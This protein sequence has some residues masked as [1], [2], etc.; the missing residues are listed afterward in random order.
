MIQQDTKSLTGDAAEWN[1]LSSG[2]LNYS[3]AHRWQL[4][5][6]HYFGAWLGS[7]TT[8]D[9]LSI[10][11]VERRW[12]RDPIVSPLLMSCRQNTYYQAS[13]TIARNALNARLHLSH[14]AEGTNAVSIDGSARWFGLDA[15]REAGWQ[16]GTHGFSGYN[17]RTTFPATWLA[18]NMSTGNGSSWVTSNF[19]MY[20]R[21]FLR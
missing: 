21:A 4:G 1:A 18:N 9:W 12:S 6:V 8:R 16:G 19:I 10:D 14:N 7:V 11:E 2:A 15:V 13:D 17:D 3:V 5:V 20:S